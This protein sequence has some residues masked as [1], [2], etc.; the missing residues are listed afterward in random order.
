MMLGIPAIQALA[1]TAFA[2]GLIALS[3]LRFQKTIE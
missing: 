2:M 1:L 3:V